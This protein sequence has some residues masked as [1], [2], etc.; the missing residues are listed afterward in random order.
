MQT[1]RIHKSVAKEIE[2]L[3]PELRIRIAEILDFL[4]QGESIGMPLSRSMPDIA[5]GS[6]ELRIKDK[7]GQYRVFYYTK[8]SNMLMVFHFFKKKGQS[9]PKKELDIAQKRLRSML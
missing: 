2:K 6:H 7:R 8:V 5:G 4:A 3:N 9:T 1:I